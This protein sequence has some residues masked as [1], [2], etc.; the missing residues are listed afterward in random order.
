M[1]DE[2]I[3]GTLDLE[4]PGASTS[5]ESLTIDVESFGTYPNA[6]A[7][8]FIRARSSTGPAPS[9]CRTTSPA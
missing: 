3:N 2:V 9:R 8:Y 5:V 1:P 6:I 7:S 4:I